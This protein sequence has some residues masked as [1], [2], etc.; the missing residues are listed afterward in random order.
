MTRAE[1]ERYRF[2]RIGEQG[3]D[4]FFDWA[5]SWTSHEGLLGEV[6][7]LGQIATT[8]P[9]TVIALNHAIS[10]VCIAGYF[11]VALTH[12]PQVY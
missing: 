6:P 3:Q 11:P 12:R 1:A 5:T 4:R 10:F 9:E 2:L 8:A 7:L